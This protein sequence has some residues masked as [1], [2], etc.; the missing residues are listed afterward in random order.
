MSDNT[1]DLEQAWTKYSFVG[2]D[3][4]TTGKYPYSAEVCEIGAVKWEN[5]EIVGRFEAL[6]KPTHQ[7]SETVIKI[8]GITNEMVADKPPIADVIG[9]FV[10]FIEGSICVAHHAPF[11]LGFLAPEI[12]RKSLDL[13]T[14]PVICSSLLSRKIIPTSPNHRLQT[15]IK[16]LGLDQGTAHRAGDDAKACL[17]VT[18]ECMNRMGPMTP[19]GEVL[20]RQGGAI[21]WSRFSKG[22]LVVEAKWDRLIRALEAGEDVEMIYMGGS[23]PG[24]SRTVKPEGLVRSLNGD[25]LVASD[26]KTPFPKRYYLN[27]IKDILIGI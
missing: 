2:F 1:F 8:H 18:I 26:G 21:H 14:L 9:E 5:G 12:E 11:D 13:S 17:E 20:N 23:K 27:K 6:I 25:F 7:M 16:Y 19:L 22:G 4:E 3:T 10:E 24:T 15:L